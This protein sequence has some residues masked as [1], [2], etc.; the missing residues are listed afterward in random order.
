VNYVP[1]LKAQDNIKLLNLIPYCQI[2][3]NNLLIHHVLNSIF[4]KINQN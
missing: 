3:L 4:Y 1:I 2:W